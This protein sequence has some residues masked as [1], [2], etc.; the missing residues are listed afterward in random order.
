MV[1]Y[2][3]FETLLI[4]DSLPKKQ[5]EKKIAKHWRCFMETRFQAEPATPLSWTLGP[6]KSSVQKDGHSCGVFVLMNSAAI[7]SYI[8]PQVM[9]LCHVEAYRAYVREELL[10]HGKLDKRSLACD[11][12][13]CTASYKKQIQCYSCLRWCHH[14]CLGTREKDFVE[15]CIYCA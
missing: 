11:L 6:I 5:R 12:P 4:L 9:R 8:S 3:K 7:L 1:G 13:F 2:P 14:A 10:T 15:T